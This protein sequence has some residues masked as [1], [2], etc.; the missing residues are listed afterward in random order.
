MDGLTA[1]FW[2]WRMMPGC[3][4]G[5]RAISRARAFGSPPPAMPRRRATKLRAIN[6]DLMVLDV[7]MP[8]ESGLDLDQSLR[9]RARTRPA[10]PAAD[11]ARRAG[12][13]HRR[14]RGRAPTTTWASRSSR[15]NWCCASAP[16]C[17]ARRRRRRPSRRSGPMRIGAAEFDLERGELRDAAGPIRL[18]GGEAALA[19]RAGAQG[20]RGAVARG[21][22]RGAGHGR[23][24]R[25]RHRRPGRAPA[26]Q[27][28][29]RSARAALPAYRARPG[30]HPEARVSEMRA[31]IPLPFGRR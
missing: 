23:F 11:R 21:D 5:W 31:R 26:P 9:A 27:D 24:G 16:C 28:R 25:A 22:R 15:A 1:T 14:V 18:T 7:M 30:L 3:G 17:A 2:S 29:G 12:G 13:P 6:P 8:G 19:D 10:G 4:S 20:Q